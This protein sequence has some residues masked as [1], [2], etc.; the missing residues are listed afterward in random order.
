MIRVAVIGAGHWGPNLIRNFENPPASTVRWVVD[1][2][3]SRL[4]QVRSRYP[5]VRLSSKSRTW[6]T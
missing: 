6:G 5:D 2:D 4:E 3:E 1:R